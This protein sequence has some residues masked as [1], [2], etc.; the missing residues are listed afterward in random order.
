MSLKLVLD[1]GLLGAMH[2]PLSYPHSYDGIV[3]LFK[4]V[5]AAAKLIVVN[6]YRKVLSSLK[7]KQVKI[8]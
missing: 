6:V 1:L 5:T 4:Y 8:W 2:Y 3:K 7:N